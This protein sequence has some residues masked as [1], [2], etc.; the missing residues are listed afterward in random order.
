MS[1]PITARRLALTAVATAAL[2]CVGV[3]GAQAQKGHLLSPGSSGGELDLKRWG[4]AL[5]ERAGPRGR[6]WSDTE[7]AVNSA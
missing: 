4:A 5:H 3:A 1:Y 2:M 7:Q 6:S